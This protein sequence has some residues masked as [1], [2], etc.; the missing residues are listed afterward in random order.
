MARQETFTGKHALVLGGAK[1]IGAALCA[2]F[3]RRGAR[4]SVADIDLA[5]AE[6]TASAIM[7]G[8]AEGAAIAVDVLS[9][10][11]IGFAVAAAE[12]RFGP[13]DIL[14]N[15]VGAILNGAFEDIPPEAWERIEDLNHRAVARGVRAVLPAMLARGSGHIVNTA[16]F[17][18]AYPYASTRLPYAA[19]KAAVISLSQNL[20]LQYEPQGL[21][22]SCLIP[23]PVITGIAV[24]MPNFS[25][26]APMRGPGAGLSLLSAEE[27]ARRFADG[28]AAGRILI[29]SDEALWD[30]LRDWAADPDAFVRRKIAEAARGEWG[31]PAR[32]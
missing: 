4:V 30:I 29:P 20:A 5:A 12:N 25:P 14:V 21:R 9:A 13:V 6:E 8:G 31:M 3:A 11:S 16:S 1:G 22:I 10:E 26:D 18:G 24:G 28:M 7:T 19:S 17:A 2:E 23:G 27:A 15:N 32:P